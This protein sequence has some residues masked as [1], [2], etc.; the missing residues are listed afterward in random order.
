MLPN[1][2]SF[3][4]TYCAF[5]YM[6]ILTYKAGH[7]C[8][9]SYFQNLF[10]SEFSTI[11]VFSILILMSMPTL[12]THIFYVIKLCSKKKVFKI[13]TCRI[14]ATMKNI[15]PLWN[16]LTS[17]LFIYIMT[18]KKFFVISINRRVSATTDRVAYTN[19]A[20]LFVNN[21]FYRFL[22]V[23]LTNSRQGH[24]LSYFFGT[25]TAFISKRNQLLCFFRMMKTYIHNISFLKYPALNEVCEKALR[26][27]AQ[28]NRILFSGVSQT[29]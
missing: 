19:M 9:F 13:N 25:M 6:V 20:A 2:S 28:G 10:F 11:I 14:I 16:F 15:Y 21:K 29:L 26:F 27:N 23:C 5:A 1:Y 4:S 22:T 7:S 17:G 12:C 8:I 18:H 3:N 24:F